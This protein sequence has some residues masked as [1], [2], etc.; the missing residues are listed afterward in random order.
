M[1]GLSWNY[2]GISNPC[3]VQMLCELNRTRKP[4]FIFLTETLARNTKISQIKMRLGFE[5]MVNTDCAGR[6]GGLA[7]L[8]KKADEFSLVGFSQNHIEM[9]V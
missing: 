2:R 8:W 7:F 4:D 3:T 6:A 1:I 9:A 5:G